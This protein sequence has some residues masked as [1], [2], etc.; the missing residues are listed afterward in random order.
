MGKQTE[1]IVAHGYLVLEVEDVLS[2][3]VSS[4]VVDAVAPF[5]VGDDVFLA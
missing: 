1:I 5:S 2:V 3:A 4:L